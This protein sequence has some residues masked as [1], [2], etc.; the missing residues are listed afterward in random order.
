M[1]AIDGRRAASAPAL[2]STGPSQPSATCGSTSGRLVRFRVLVEPGLDTTPAQFVRDILSVLC[3][4]RSWIAS[5]KVRFRYDPAGSLL[6]GLRTPDSTEDRCQQLIGL[7]VGYYYSCASRSEAVLNADRW[8]NGSRYWP[9]SV[10]E[11]RRMLVNHEVGHTQGQHH[12]NCV[13]DGGP[14]PAMM[15]QSK[16]LSSGGDTCKPNAWPLAYEL[17]SL[18]S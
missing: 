15:Q 13:R 1:G 10:N 16:G 9:G 11:Y 2:F 17:R 14:A 12:R 6:I 18:Y 8:F 3:D 4:Q 7:S 5:G